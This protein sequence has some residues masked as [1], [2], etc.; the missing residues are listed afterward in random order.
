MK[1]LKGCLTTII[2]FVLIC[3]VGYCFYRNNV[4]SNLENSSKNVEENWG[5][6]IENINLRNKKLILETI[7]NDTLQH[8]LKLSKD[9]EKKEFSREF[10]YIEY[11]INE[12]LMFENIETDFNEKLNSNVD[13]YNQSVREYNV[14]RVT[15]PNSLIARKMDYPK[16]FKYFDIIRYGIE[17]ENPK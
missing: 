5:K 9:I 15:F 11:K 14:Y 2:A 7:K 12:N 17:N 10:E 6:Y 4:I 1:I 16:S 8:Y 13:V 3:A